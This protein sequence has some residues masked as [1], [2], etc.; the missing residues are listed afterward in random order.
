MFSSKPLFST[1]AVLALV[2]VFL[3]GSDARVHFLR[4][5]GTSYRLEKRAVPVNATYLPNVTALEY[6]ATG[7]NFTNL[8][9]LASEFSNITTTLND[10]S[11][12][13]NI[14]VFAPNDE[15]F[16]ALPTWLYKALKS[17]FSCGI[18]FGLLQYHVGTPQI[19]FSYPNRTHL[20]T[21]SLL[22][23]VDYPVII[24]DLPKGQNTT[25]ETLL[26]LNVTI[27]V[28]E[29]TS[30]SNSTVAFINDA[31]PIG[32][33]SFFNSKSLLNH[34]VT[35]SLNWFLIDVIYVSNGIVYPINKII[36]PLFY[37]N[38]SLY[39]LTTPPPGS[40]ESSTFG[41]W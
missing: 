29:S 34:S 23:T 35:H 13:A 28:H 2:I 10:T 22:F 41:L 15:A 18:T 25:V 30:D 6:L 26:G 1:L 31:E 4:H 27:Q 16:G 39:D 36:S 7:L 8:T 40:S 24:S 19:F 20:V 17:P 32:T 9:A 33:S 5:K 3:S 12:G 38:T 21:H 11:P 37:L 14:T